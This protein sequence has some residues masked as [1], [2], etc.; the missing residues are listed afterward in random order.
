ML[1]ALAGGVGASKLLV[2]LKHV[3][4]P[5]SATAIVNTADDE[6]FFGLHVSPDI[7]TVVYALA[8]IGDVEKGWGV[9]GDTFNALDM[10]ARL[11]C[12]TW[13]KL[14][15]RDLAIHIYRTMRLRQGATLTQITGEIASRLGAGWTILPM[16]DDS[17]R[18]MVETDK[19]TLPFQTYFV[20]HGYAV[21][22]LRVW[23]EGIEKA[24]PTPQVIE[25]LE[26]SK[27]IIIC[28]S[29]PVVSI[30]PILA[31]NGIRKMLRQ[32]DA[33]ILAVSPI[34]G[35]KA[36]R[37]PAAEMM[38]SLGIEPSPLGIAEL[39][40]DFLDILVMDEADADLEKEVR[41]L[42]VKT[43]V[44]KTVMKS[45]EDKVRLGKICLQMLGIVS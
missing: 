18:T 6:E 39:Y 41:A 32:I 34:V 23:F 33:S 8:G 37:G 20:K 14:G 43:V 1:T 27:S 35:G 19:G 12:E 24:R 21:K 45:F 17:V 4:F 36:L 38:E 13:F 28:P 25:A 29:N 30:G 44:T 26:N 31:L 11:G 15:D 2:G 40:R 10:L 22:V 7:D 42:G 3:M 5:R 16:T 9:A